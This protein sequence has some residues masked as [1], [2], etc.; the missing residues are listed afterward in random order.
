MTNVKNSLDLFEKGID[1][2]PRGTQ[3]MSKSPDQYVYGVHPIYLSEGKGCMVKDVDGNWYIDHPCALGPIILGYNHKRTNDAI[4]RQLKK[5]I[6]F[7]LM[8]E[9][10]VE[11]A[12]MLVD[13]IPCADQVRFGKNGS[14]VTSIAVRIARSY[15]GKEHILMPEGHYHGWHDF[16]AAVSRNYGIPK[17][18]K[19]L[20]DK[21]NYNDLDSL[22]QKIKTGKYA[23]VIMEP[24]ALEMPKEGFL[25]GVR[26]LC[27]KY[28]TILIFDEVVTGFRFGLSGAQGYFG[29]TPDLATFGKAVANGMPIS[30]LAGKKEYMNELNHVFFSATFG[31]EALSVAASIETLKEM[32]ENEEIFTHI[33]KQGQ[34]LWDAFEKY[35]KQYKINLVVK[36]YAPRQVIEFKTDDPTGCKD[37]FHQEMVKQGVLMGNNIYISWS[38]KQSHISKSIRAIKKSLKIVAE[39]YRTNTI[40]EKLEGQRSSVVFKKQITDE[41]EER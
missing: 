27:T 9:S 37:L 25:E 26:E 20:V 3:T 29:V 13:I 28:N 30:I 14:D 8:H 35:S 23:C 32:K 15:T 19:E 10:E 17:S 6:T 22:E 40:E 39:A 2:I 11:L 31:G 12:Q 34:R 38:H 36:G 24:V 41:K 33:W 21:F 16:Y 7:S 5:G 4:K 1:V 18:L